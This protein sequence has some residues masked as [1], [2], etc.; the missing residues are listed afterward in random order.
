MQKGN[1]HG[2][3]TVTPNPLKNKH[4]TLTEWIK[5]DLIL[6]DGKTAYAISKALERPINTILNE[7]RRGTVIIPDVIYH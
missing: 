3:Y 2:L 4:L 5:T 6:K 1:H 7:I